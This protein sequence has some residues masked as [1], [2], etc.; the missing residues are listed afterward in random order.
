VYSTPGVYNIIVKATDRN[1]ATAYL[2]LVGVANGP[3]S[4][5]VPGEGDAG[6]D[7]GGKRTVILWQPALIMF[8]LLI[9]SFWLGRKYELQYIKKKIARGE[10]PF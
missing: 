8:P 10:R 3:L 1:G 7:D 9:S 5:D 4:Q 6:Q 2:Q